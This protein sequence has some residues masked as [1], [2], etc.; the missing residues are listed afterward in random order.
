MK[1]LLTLTLLYSPMAHTQMKY[2]IV[3]DTHTVEEPKSKR[4][5]ASAEEKIDEVKDEQLN[6]KLVKEQH[7]KKTT[8]PIR[9]SVSH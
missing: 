9:F 4:A 3:E 6:N 1:L 5:P 7:E 8:K 2:V